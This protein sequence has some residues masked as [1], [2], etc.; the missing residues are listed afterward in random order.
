MSNTVKKT[1]PV[2]NM[3]CA[4]CANNVEKTIGHLPGVEASSVNFA[5]NILSVTY[6]LDQQT[7][8]SIRAAVVNAGYDLIIEED[9]AAERQEEKQRRN[10]RILKFRVIGAWIFALPLL[11]L[12]MV[13]M[14]VP[15]SGLIQMCLALP[16]LLIFGTPFYVGAWKQLKMGRS[17]MD[18]LVTLS[19]SI[20]FIFSVFN[21]FFPEFWIS[22]GL[23][24]HIYYEA[25]VVIIAFVLTGKLMEERA[26]GNTS[27]AIRKL[28]KLQPKTARVISKDG[29]KEVSLDQLRINDLISVRPGEQIPVDGILTEGS[30]FVDESMISG[31]PI[32]VEKNTG[33]QVLAGTINQRGSFV[34]RAVKVGRE[35]VLANIIRMVQEAQGSKA[36]VQRI[37]DKITGIFVPV[38]LG[39]SLITILIWM[40]FG[41]MDSLSRAMLSAVSVLVIACP[42]ALG[43]ATPTALMVGIGKAADEH[44]LIKDA[45]ALEVMRKVN[46][47]VLDKTGTLTEGHPTVVGWLWTNTEEEKLKNVLL[48]AELKSE[49]PLAGA[50]VASLQ[51]EN[52]K[53]VTIESFQSITGK[54][55]TVSCNGITYWA[56][57]HKLLKDYAA[58]HS[59]L[60]G[61]KLV[62]YES[63]GCSMVYFGRESELLAIAA[64]K[65]KIKDTSAMAVRQLQ[66][67]G[68]EVYMLT[69]D[70]ERTASTVARKLGIKHYTADALPG[71][72][73]LF[74]RELQLQRKTVAMVG[75]G[76]NDSQA[77]ARA[78]VSIA[79]GKG[80]D[81]AMDVA[82]VTLMTSDLSLLPKAISLSRRTVQLIHQN[83]FWAFIYN[84]IGIPIAAGILYPINGLLL[85]PM[86]ASAAMAFS[87]VSVVLNSLR[88]RK[89]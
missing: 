59:D 69:G 64:I 51:A 43:L 38:V 17:N 5:N 32:P 2:L 85:N 67:Q 72:K 79:M 68:I 73:D 42:C 3:H 18:T 28:M 66:E 53:P 39:I 9:H 25:S 15:Y 56:G 41:G 62:Q 7:P 49:H 30:S 10:Y 54:G 34:I 46:A 47:V 33:A 45:V 20:A 21:T 26:K 24:P 86:L 77:L 23:E 55:I 48:A 65:D 4:G 13:F 27:T 6:K 82:M 80:T 88:L 11:L 60:L 31:E 35:T 14:H 29:E 52:I 75:D 40:A 12:S 76:I 16:V 58:A 44:I 8:E 74:V 84:L 50:I 81:I 78:N 37:V 89:G 1:F 70:G 19:T 63:D 83:L 71:D 57:S 61:E 36:P 87:S 22:R